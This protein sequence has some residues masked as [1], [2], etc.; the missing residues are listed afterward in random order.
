MKNTLIVNAD[1][2]GI[3]ESITKGILSGIDN[4]IISDTSLMANGEAFNSAVSAFKER[5][6]RHVGMHFSIVDG[7]SPLAAKED[8]SVLLKDGVFP[9]SAKPLHLFLKTFLV[10]R[11]IKR[12]VQCEFKAQIQKIHNAGLIVSHLDSHQHIHTFYGISDVLVDMCVQ[13][14]IPF[15]R[16]PT[17]QSK[18]FTSLLFRLFS[19]RLK[20]LAEINNVTP[21]KAVGYDT[22]GINTKLTIRNNIHQIKSYE[23]AELMVHPGFSDARTLEKYGHWRCTDW[24]GE[25]SALEEVKIEKSRDEIQLISYAEYKMQLMPCPGCGN[26]SQKLKFSLTEFNIVECNDCSLLYN[27]DFLSLN[28]PSNTFSEAYYTEVQSEGFAHIWEDEKDD[29]SAP[30]YASGLEIV[31]GIAGKGNVLDVGCAFGAFL[32]VAKGRDWTVEGVELSTYSSKVARDKYGLNVHTGELISA[33]LDR[34]EYDLITFWDVLEH[35]TDVDAQIKKAASLVKPSG[36]LILITD[37][38]RSLISFIAKTF[39][40]L[41]FGIIKYPMKKFFIPY[42]S[43]YFVREDM[44][45]ILERHNF[46]VCHVNGIDHPIER[47]NLGKAEK[48]ILS[49][50]YWLG[51]KLGCQSQF[52]MIAKKQND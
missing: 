45:K 11:Q 6:I 41:S 15:I 29:P 7:E 30:I 40:Y 39:Y 33:Q 32:Q 52:I 48:L 3:T 13:Y 23:V 21:V 25:L 37:S 4:G 43:C 18:D 36:H 44:T 1:D 8:V 12:A 19:F 42:N 34:E 28:E 35:V 5:G 2:F 31:E 10:S 14:K 22:T 38:Y 46:K 20:R 9:I 47:I 27:R 26:D 49:I 24:E 16:V 17:S 50:L 51:E